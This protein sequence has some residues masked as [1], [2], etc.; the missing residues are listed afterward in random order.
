M[1]TAEGDTWKAHLAILMVQFFYG[2]YQVITKVA[3]NDGVNQLVFCVYRDFIALTIVAPI[4]FFQERRTRPPITKKLLMSFFF[5][6]L[7]GM[8]GN[9]LLFLVGLS[10]T[11]PTCAAAIQPAVSVFT[12]L[13]AVMMGIE[14]V[15][16]LRYEGLAKVGGILI[17]VSGAILMVFYRGPVLIGYTIMGHEAQ[18]EITRRGHPEP[19]GWLINGLRDIGLDQFQQGVI[20]L[21]GNSMCMA[22]FLAIQAP[23]LK[24]YPASLSITA[25]SFFFGVLLVV[26]VSFFMTN[27]S[28]DWIFKQSEILAVV[29]SGIIASAL[30]Y[31]LIT[32]SNKILGPALVALYMPLQPAFAALPSQIFL[33]S[34]IFLGRYNSPL[35]VIDACLSNLIK[36]LQPTNLL[37]KCKG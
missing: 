7:T 12:F 16:L 34:P 17:C 5:L 25:Y 13:F 23:L 4:A 19:S 15:N 3:L 9:Q 18:S 1:A 31:G 33:G 22:V 27:W 8:F 11:N 6:G 29:Y 21:I 37:T 30:N 20:F 10:Y 32:W 24:K 14:R 26:I 35:I 2:V 36:G 28:T